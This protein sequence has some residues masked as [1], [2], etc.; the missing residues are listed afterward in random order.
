MDANSLRLYKSRA[1]VMKA[2]AHPSRLFIADKLTEGEYCVNELTAFVGC[3]V[4]TMS[5][6][7]AILKNAGVVQ[8]ERRGAC[9]YYT[10]RIPCIPGFFGCAD[11]VIKAGEPHARRA[12]GRRRT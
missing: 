11:A 1:R 5:R 2:L 4:S 10:L 12:G 7:L 3:D 8:D 9:I 6:H